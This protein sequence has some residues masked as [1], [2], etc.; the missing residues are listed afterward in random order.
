MLFQM[1]SLDNDT[2]AL[3][4]KRAFD[5]AASTRGVK[6][7]LNGKLLP[8]KC[9]KDYVDLCLKVRFISKAKAKLQVMLLSI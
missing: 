8:I 5:V 3:L 9:F 6:V 2:V 7:Y 4:S 1:E